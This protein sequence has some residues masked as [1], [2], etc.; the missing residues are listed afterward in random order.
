MECLFCKIIA[1]EMPATIVFE[2]E[3]IMAFRD[4][5]PQAPTHL[6]IVP[7][8]HIAT[9]NDTHDKDEALLGHIVGTATKLARTSGL[10]EAGYR[11]IFNTNEDGGQAVYHIHLHI[12][13][14]RRMSWPP[15]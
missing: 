9:L 3:T 14:G 7:K 1:G 10:G 11:L 13:G 8:K 2:D 5:S 15:G 12:L 6:L 4:I